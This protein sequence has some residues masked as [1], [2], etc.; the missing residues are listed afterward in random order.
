VEVSDTFIA[1]DCRRHPFVEIGGRRYI[2]PETLAVIFDVSS[3][4]VSRWEAR[5]QGPPRIP[6]SKMLLD[7]LLK[8]I[9]RRWITAMTLFMNLIPL[10]KSYSVTTVNRRLQR[11]P[12]RHPKGT[13]FVATYAQPWMF[14]CSAD[15]GR[16]FIPA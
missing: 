8:I 7:D 2:R 1:I 16:F 9:T 6:L 11:T 15:G 10:Q 12:Y 4:T 5:R 13:P 3:R 14:L